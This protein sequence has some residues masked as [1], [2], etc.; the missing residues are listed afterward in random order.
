[1]LFPSIV[2]EVQEIVDQ[3]M[4]KL[5]QRDEGWLLWSGKN[6]GAGRWLKWCH[7]DTEERSQHLGGESGGRKVSVFR[8]YCHEHG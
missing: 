3:C 4:F 6:N 8:R 7:W 1:M 2:P 5:V